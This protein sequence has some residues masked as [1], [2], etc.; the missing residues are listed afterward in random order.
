MI[1]TGY[2]AFDQQQNGCVLVCVTDQPQCHRLIKAGATI[3]ANSQRQLQVVSVMPPR[4]VTPNTADALQTL[5]NISSKLGAEMTVYFNEEPALTVAV[6]SRKIN[7]THL[8][9]G[10]P[11]PGHNVFVELVRGLVPDIPLSLVDADGQC[12][13]FPAMPKV[14]ANQ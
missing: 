10:V 1:Q 11:G 3:A 14:A 7:A 4:L 6:H 2:D 12:I 8:V 5:H 9:M 13:S